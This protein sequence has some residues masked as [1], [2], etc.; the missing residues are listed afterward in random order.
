MSKINYVIREDNL[1]EMITGESDFD[2]LDTEKILSNYPY[3]VNSMNKEKYYLE[4]ELCFVFDELVY[5]NKVVGFATYEFNDES[6][7]MLT[8]CYIIPEFRGNRIFFN[9]L[10]KMI[11]SAPEF[12]ILQPTRNIVELLIDYSFAR[13][14][15]DD[16]VIS[17]IDFYLDEFDAR[18]NKKDAISEE[19]QYTNYYDLKICS[20]ILIDDDEV[21]YHEL[22]END[23]RRYGKRKEL[24]NEYFKSITE[25]FKENED[26]FEELEMELIDN[27][28]HEKFGY[29]EI[30]GDGEDLSKFMQEMVDNKVISYEY[31]VEI[32]QELMRKYESGEITDETIED[33]FT[34]MIINGA[35]DFIT[36]EGFQKFLNSVQD[37]G[38]DAQALKQFFDIVGSDEKLGEDIFRAMILDDEDEFENIILNA[39]ENNEELYDNLIDLANDFEDNDE[40]EFYDDEYLDMESLGLNLDSPYP[41]AEMMWGP[42]DEQYKLDNTFYGKD[43]PISHDNYMFRVLKSLKKHNNLKIALATA[44]MKGAMTSHAVESLL[45]MQ[46]FISTEVNY[47]N[48]DEFAN[49]SLTVKDLKNILRKNNLKISGKKQDLIDRVAENQIPLDEF[50]S[51]KV[52]V[53]PEGEEFIQNNPWIDFYYTF[54]GK[55]DFNDFVKYL[56]NNEGEFIEITLGY[57]EQHLK[58]AKKEKDSKYITDCISAHDMISENGESYLKSL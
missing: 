47:D 24:D 6:V 36:F 55:F 51:E 35:S 2:F 29:D 31:A 58:K 39:M 8:E 26:E 46:K 44:D 11:F 52:T 41:V 49:D 3:I 38:E 28:P 57:L 21:I 40:L 12:G 34:M 16:I 43:Y 1:G 54:L 23:L 22:L 13:N 7:L 27:L 33:E 17:G 5:E 10:S 18:S 50:T 20:S 56:D 19:L 14:V 4:N 25:L 53:T 30:I 15:T 42:N 32:R 9:E 45:F 37:E 48:W